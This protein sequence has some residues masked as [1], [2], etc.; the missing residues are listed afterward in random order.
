MA[1]FSVFI[2]ARKDSGMPDLTVKVEASNWLVALKEGLKQIGEQGDALAN[3]VC[4][5]A[6][7]GSLRVADP[8]SRRVFVVSQ[9][10]DTEEDDWLEKQ[11]EEQATQSRIEAEKAANEW[12]T[13]NTALQDFNEKTQHQMKAV[14]E[15]AVRRQKELEKDATEAR[16]K[17]DRAASAAADRAMGAVGKVEV[18]EGSGGSTWDDLDDW[19]DGV[20]VAEQTL[21]DVLSDLFLATDDL[22]EKTPLEAAA[23]I[24]DIAENH[25]GAQA[26]SVFYSDMNSPLKDL[27]VS[28]AKGPVSKKI[29]GARVPMGKGNV[30][31]SVQNGVRLIV[32]NVDKNPNFYGKLD[33]K[34]GFSTR[35]ILC[36]PIQYEERTFGA[37]ELVNRTDGE[38][39]TTFD[40]NIVESLGKI[41][42]RA[43]ETH[44]ATRKD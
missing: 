28:A 14:D 27:V 23:F 26:A 17:A 33:E 30:G 24:L 21:D 29:L 2:P 1:N 11:A 38:D 15:E 7:D 8:G 35:S 32:N 5:T 9:V 20:D 42:G 43:V 18:T 12:A 19:Y 6:P 31:F 13:K 37:I 41:L 25:V 44:V 34:L 16:E 10:A 40:S 4:E 36:A 39:W 22:H 3:I